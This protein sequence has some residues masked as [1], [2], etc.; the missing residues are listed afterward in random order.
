MTS[1]MKTY[2]V[3]YAEDVPHYSYGEIEARNDKDAL[4]KARKIDTETF[5]AYEP[6]WDHPVCR[7][8]VSIEAADGKVIAEDVALDK[9]VLHKGT[10]AHQQ[11][12]DAAE[13]MF[14]ALKAVAA[15]ICKHGIADCM[16]ESEWVVA[17]IHAALAKAR[18]QQ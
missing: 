4:T 14:A 8:I 7:R 11:R 5:G 18:G 12:L 16:N 10:P 13:E 2:T 17:K 15:F 3:L 1:R 6:D 9:Y